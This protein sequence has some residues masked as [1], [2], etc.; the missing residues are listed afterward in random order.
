MPPKERSAAS[1]RERFIDNAHYGNGTGCRCCDLV[2]EGHLAVL[3]DALEARAAM[4][5]IFENDVPCPE[6]W[7]TPE[8]YDQWCG[9]CFARDVLAKATK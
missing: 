8:S 9:P 6:E 2:D 7:D 1:L 4:P 3:L 5:C